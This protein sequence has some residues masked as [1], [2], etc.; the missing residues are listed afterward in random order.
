MLFRSPMEGATMTELRDAGKFLIT[1]Q[2]WG[3][4]WLDASN[5]LSIFVTGNF[6]NAGRYSSEAFDK[7]YAEAM[8]NYD[9]EERL[10]LLHEAEKQLVVEDMG[11]IPLYHRHAIA[12][13]RDSD[14][15]NVKFDADRKVMWADIIVNK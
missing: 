6:I 3:P 4:D 2:G 9:T 15:S 13:Y 11:I 8:Y 5:M 10:N 1:P 12:L 7:A 14:L